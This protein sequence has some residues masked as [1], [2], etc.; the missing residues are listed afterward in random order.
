M[1]AIKPTVEMAHPIGNGTQRLYRFDNG[2]GA[3][4]VRFSGSY[5]NEYGLWELA[6]IKWSGESYEL[7]YDTP[8]TDDVIGWLSDD[9]VQ[10]NLGKIRGLPAVAS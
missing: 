6:V 5:G 4:V 10:D 7:T 9:E 1:S 8:V 3:S 2:Y